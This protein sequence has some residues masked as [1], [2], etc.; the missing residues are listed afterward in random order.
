MKEGVDALMRTRTVAVPLVAAGLLASY[1]AA[2]AADIA[3]GWITAA[4]PHAFPAPFPSVAAEPEGAPSPAPVLDEDAPLPS[5]SE[6]QRLAQGLRGDSRTGRRASVSVVDIAT[7]AVLADAGASSPRVPASTAK[8]LTAA[9]VYRA[10]GPDFRLRTSLTWSG[11]PADSGRTPVTLVAGGDIMLAAGSGHGGAKRSAN[12]YA[13]LDDLA[14]QAAETLRS[15]G[16]SR[17]SVGY[18][19]SRFEGPDLNPRWPSSAFSQGWV[20]PATGLAVNLAKTR[21]ADYPPRYR[22]PSRHAAEVLA[23]RL[24][25]HG[26]DATVAGRRNAGAVEVAGVESAPLVDVL[27]YM[28]QA[29]D[30]TVPE[31]LVMVL[32]LEEGRAGTVSAGVEEVRRQARELGVDLDGVVMYDGSGYGRDD[33][34]TAEALTQVLAALGRDETLDDLLEVLPIGGFQGTLEDRFRS[35][36]ATGLVRAKTGSLTGVTSL[37]GTVVTEDGRWLAFAVLADG[38][39]YGQDAPR[40]AIDEFIQ[41]LASCGCGG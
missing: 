11:A 10:L 40:A 6:I 2:D 9:A 33:R 24:E 25:D 19:D 20:A 21:N 38:L 35:G 32:A 28:L 27:A 17:V 34:A 26:I 41:A 36:A 13:G 7:G 31:V 23:S 14:E 5:A 37:A 30:N 15:A 8:L 4:P 16:V 18:D 1:L 12:G 29:S 39:P 22:D 3:P